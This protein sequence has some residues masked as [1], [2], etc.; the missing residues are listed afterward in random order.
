MTIKPDLEPNME[1]IDVHFACV[2]ASLQALWEAGNVPESL[3]NRPND[4]VNKTVDS[5]WDL[6]VENGCIRCG[7]IRTN[8]ERNPTGGDIEGVGDLF[9]RLSGFWL[10][11]C[12]KDFERGRAL[13][14]QEQQAIDDLDAAL[15]FYEPQCWPHSRHFILPEHDK[16]WTLSYL[17]G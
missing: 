17:E 1:V 5:W 13:T 2:E 4:W 16:D 15:D 6:F 9:Q 7:L 3:K 10:F 14:I 8:W 12:P 11:I